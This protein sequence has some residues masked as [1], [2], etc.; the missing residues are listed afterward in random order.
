MA[1]GAGEVLLKGKDRTL[2]FRHGLTQPK[3]PKKEINGEDLF[4]AQF[5]SRKDGKL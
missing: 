1:M 2:G 4:E 5:S 3:W